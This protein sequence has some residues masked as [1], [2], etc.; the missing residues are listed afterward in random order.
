M[1]RSRP[2]LLIAIA[3]GLSFASPRGGSARQP[4]K[5]H[6]METASETLW[7]VR[8]TNCGYG[9]YVSLPAGAVGHATL[10]PSP[11]HGF[12][13]A[14]PDVGTMNYVSNQ[15]G[16]FIWV[17]ASYNT[18]DADSLAGLVAERDSGLT[19]H[20]LTQTKVAG[21]PA[22]RIKSSDRVGASNGVEVTTVALRRGI[23]Y[24]IG[25]RTNGTDA[26]ADEAAYTRIV[27]GL[28]L[29]TLP[30]GQCTNG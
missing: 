7:T 5:R 12:L 28:K 26:D 19:K 4:L 25:L 15:K 3:V 17:D 6:W 13:I 9:Y 30:R 2:K 22:V 20:S 8:Y 10:P 14:L 11:N 16:R 18:S 23:I 29:L 21:L 1:Q 24:T 27:H